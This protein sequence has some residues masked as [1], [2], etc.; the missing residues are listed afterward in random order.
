MILVIGTPDSGK[1]AYAEELAVKSSGGAYMA[2]IA[3]MI[4]FGD[5]GEKGKQT[6]T[7]HKYSQKAF[8]YY[9]HEFSTTPYKKHKSHKVDNI[10]ILPGKYRI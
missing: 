7:E 8:F 9:I 2:Y 4:P 6:N 1:S 10:I 3:T 5:E